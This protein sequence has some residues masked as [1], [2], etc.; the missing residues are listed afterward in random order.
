MVGYGNTGR[1]LLRRLLMCSVYIHRLCLGGDVEK[2]RQ[3]AASVPVP[4]LEVEFHYIPRI[5]NLLCVFTPSNPL[6]RAA[7]PMLRLMARFRLA[8][9][10]PHRAAL[11]MFRFALFLCRCFRGLQPSFASDLGR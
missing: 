6:Q 4:S 8:R 9:S 7:P 2:L 1:V 11:L 10:T 5:S 3:T